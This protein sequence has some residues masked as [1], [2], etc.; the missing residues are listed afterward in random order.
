MGVSLDQNGGKEYMREGEGEVSW[1]RVW[2]SR[3]AGREGE[4]KGKE[5]EVM[6]E[7]EQVNMADG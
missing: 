4:R 1:G 3:G 5:G 7:Q 2:A 6:G